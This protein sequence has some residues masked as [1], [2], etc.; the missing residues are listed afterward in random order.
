MPRHRC[1]W[2]GCGRAGVL[3]GG[4]GIFI[5]PVARIRVHRRRHVAVAAW[6]RGWLKIAGGVRR[7]R[8]F[9]SGWRLRATVRRRGSGGPR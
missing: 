3:L 2:V 9:K 6:E 4:A 8:A 5:C 7:R 1:A